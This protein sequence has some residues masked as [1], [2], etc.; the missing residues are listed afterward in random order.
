MYRYQM[1]QQRPAGLWFIETRRAR[2]ISVMTHLLLGEHRCT[3]YA[4]LLPDENHPLRMLLEEWRTEHAAKSQRTC[5]NKN[6]Q[7]ACQ[8]ILLNSRKEHPARTDR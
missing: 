8:S 1:R 3:P 4:R 5:G 6:M 2:S 7:S